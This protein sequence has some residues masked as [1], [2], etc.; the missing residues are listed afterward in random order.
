M[1]STW[2]AV[3]AACGLAASSLSGAVQTAPPPPRVI[4]LWPEGVPG[5]IPNAG[6]EVVA[7]GRVSNVHEPTLAFYSAAPGTTTRSAVIVCPGGGCQRLSIEKEGTAVAA[8]LNSLGVSAF[9][10]KSRLKENSVLFYSALRRAGVAAE[11]HVYER[12]P[13]GFGLAPD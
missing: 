5:A 6:P 8:W 4:A 1:K 7:D 3:V 12:G 9:V 10:L 11:L 2:L 13:H